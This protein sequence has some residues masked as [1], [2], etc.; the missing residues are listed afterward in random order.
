MMCLHH[1]SKRAHARGLCPRC[2][3][4]ARGRVKAGTWTWVELETSGHARPPGKRGPKPPEWA[5]TVPLSK[6]VH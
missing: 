5:D 1:P 4:Y 3:Q 2:F 6:D